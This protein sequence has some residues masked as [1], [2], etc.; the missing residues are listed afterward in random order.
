ML[1][2]FVGDGPASTRHEL[3]VVAPFQLAHSFTVPSE[4]AAPASAGGLLGC[5]LQLKRYAR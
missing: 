2:S 3:T 1:R 4:P 5:P